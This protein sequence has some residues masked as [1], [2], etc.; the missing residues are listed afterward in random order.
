MPC[1]N[2]VGASNYDAV[3]RLGDDLLVAS[4]VS[5]MR[6]FL[7]DNKA[8]GG[9]C[10]MRIQSPSWQGGGQDFFIAIA[11]F[12]G[13]R[14]GGGRRMDGSPR[15]QASCWQGCYW[16][17]GLKEAAQ[18]VDIHMEV[19]EQAVEGMAK[20]GGAV[21]FEKEVADPGRSIAEQG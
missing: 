15:L 14:E 6:V 19:T 3:R 11:G 13:A 1:L 16:L 8:L 9:V 18:D 7:T 17:G 21:V 5:G 20:G 12:C 10:G 2:A 4:A